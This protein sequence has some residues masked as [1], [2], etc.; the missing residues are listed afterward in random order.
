MRSVVA[1]RL[2]APL[3]LA[4]LLPLPVAAATLDS[5]YATLS[6][7]QSHAGS[8]RQTRTLKGLSFPVVSEGV[9]F[10]GNG[11]GFYSET[12][13]PLYQAVSYSPAGAL[14][15]DREG[16]PVTQ[17]RNNPAGQYVSEMLLA[18]FQGDRKTIEEIFSVTLEQ[19]GN[20]AAWQLLLTPRKKA[21][22]EYIREIRIEGEREIRQIA[23]QASSGDQTLILFSAISAAENPASYCRYFPRASAA[24]CKR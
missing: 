16:K 24:H 12:E 3:L 20:G 17:N 10:F 14:A 13:K 7:Q 6:V 23:V 15:W 22:A 2:L 8:F 11:M 5:I 18:F 21:V 19:G 9:F 1:A 4:T